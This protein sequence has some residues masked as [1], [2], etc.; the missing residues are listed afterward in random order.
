MTR[1]TEKVYIVVHG[2]KHD[3]P[4]EIEGVYRHLLMARAAAAIVRAN[5]IAPYREVE[6]DRWSSRHKF[7]AIEEHAVQDARGRKSERSEARRCS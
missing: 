1:R 4:T 6:T 5:D 7:V 3:D 2:Y